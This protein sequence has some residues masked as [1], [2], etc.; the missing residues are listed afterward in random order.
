METLFSN[1]SSRWDY[2]AVHYAR[3]SALVAGSMY[4]SL[5]IIAGTTDL[6]PLLVSKSQISASIEGVSDATLQAANI[7]VATTY[8]GRDVLLWI[9]P[10]G[11][12]L[13]QSTFTS[14]LPPAFVPADNQVAIAVGSAVAARYIQLRS[15]DGFDAVDPVDNPPTTVGSWEPIPPNYRNWSNVGIASSTTFALLRPAQFRVAAPPLRSSSAYAES[16]ND[17]KVHGA[18]AAGGRSTDE[19]DVVSFWTMDE[20]AARVFRLTRKIVASRDSPSG[21]VGVEKDYEEVRLYAMMGSALVDAAIANFESKLYYYTWRPITAIRKA[22]VDD[23]AGTTAD[24]S[25]TALRNADAS[26]EYPS[27]T[28]ALCAAAGK[29][30]INH[31]KFDIDISHIAVPYCEYTPSATL[32]ANSS[33]LSTMSRTFTS[34]SNMIEEC[35]RSRVLGGVHFSFST[36]AGITQAY[37][38]SDFIYSSKFDVG[39]PTPTNTSDL[40]YAGLT[41]AIIVIGVLLGVALVVIAVFVGV[42]FWRAGKT[43]TV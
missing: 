36:K 43:L 34:I 3:Y 18:A 42:R 21:T 19:D 9:F 1:V 10:S 30:L 26:P 2:P 25:W 33:R 6:K 12:S 11:S 35:A 28:A 32:C 39:E 4:D 29:I 17:V 20:P 15:N 37:N 5:Q 23:N 40:G 16:F 8:A 27:A 22:D 14:L 41:I 38:V 31:Y 7:Q 24:P 13:I